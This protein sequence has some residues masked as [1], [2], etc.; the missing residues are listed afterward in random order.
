MCGLK[1]KKKK[2]F[3]KDLKLLNSILLIVSPQKWSI[4]QAHACIL[5]LFNV[6][7]YN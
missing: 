1:K 5:N 2:Y 6:R 7:K 4:I 3:M